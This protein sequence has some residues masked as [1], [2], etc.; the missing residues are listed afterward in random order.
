VVNLAWRCRRVYI[1]D[2]CP[3]HTTGELPAEVVYQQSCHRQASDPTV[4]NPTPVVVV[5]VEAARVDNASRLDNLTSKMALEDPGRGSTDPNIPIDNQC[6]DDE[7]H[8]GMPGGSVS[9]EDERD[10]SDAIPTTN[11]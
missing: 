10:E 3:E 11:Q 8:F 9:F 5:S 2:E 4:G 7:Q 1:F 6:T